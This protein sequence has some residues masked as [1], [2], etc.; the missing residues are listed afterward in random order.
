MRRRGIRRPCAPLSKRSA[1]PRPRKSAGGAVKSRTADRRSADRRTS[2][3]MLRTDRRRRIPR[4]SRRPAEK[5]FPSFELT[6][7]VKLLAVRDLRPLPGSPTYSSTGPRLLRT[8]PARRFKQP[9]GSGLQSRAPAV[10]DTGM[11]RSGASCGIRPP[12]HRPHIRPSRSRTGA[13]RRYRP[14]A[15]GRSRR[16]PFPNAPTVSARERARVPPFRFRTGSA[17]REC[18]RCI[19]SVFSRLR[20]RPPPPR[21]AHVLT[22]ARRSR[23]KRD[24]ARLLQASCLRTLRP[25]ASKIRTVSTASR[26]SCTRRIVAPCLRHS[27][28]R[29][30]VP[31]NASSGVVPSSL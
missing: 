3:A 24:A 20:T 6:P 30:T 28:P 29:A 16:R 10:P 12:P 13:S 15:N 18:D 25:K 4:T 22:P 9:D 21:A 2:P 31:A 7:A 8:N 5:R 17:A 1:P 23:V 19:R 26:V 14:P 11:Q 27:Q